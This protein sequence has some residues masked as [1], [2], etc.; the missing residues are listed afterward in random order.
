VVSQDSDGVAE[1]MRGGA[2]VG[3]TL[4]AQTVEALARRRQHAFQREA[5]EQQGQ[6]EQLE[7]R[8]RAL[9]IRGVREE[10]AQNQR[11]RAGA[12]APVAEIW[13]EPQPR[14]EPATASTSSPASGVAVEAAR[15]RVVAESAQAHPATA[16]LDLPPPATPPLTPQGPSAHTRSRQASQQAA[17]QAAQRVQGQGR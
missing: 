14:K 8:A 11:D 6:A 2:Q 12:N 3:L 1:A 7:R 4:A 5:A 9:D 15:V 13:P 10:I 17:R 16:V